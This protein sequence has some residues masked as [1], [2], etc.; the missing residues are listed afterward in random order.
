MAY[1]PL[2]LIATV[3]WKFFTQ[4]VDHSLVHNVE[5]C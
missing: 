1:I 5:H 2:S 3:R 4:Y